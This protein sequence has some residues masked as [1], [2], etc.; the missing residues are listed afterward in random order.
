MLGQPETLRVHART[1]AAREPYARWS[2]SP[3][4]SRSRSRRP[5]IGSG[6]TPQVRLAGVWPGASLLAAAAGAIGSGRQLARGQQMVGQLGTG[7]IRHFSYVLAAT[8]DDNDLPGFELFSESGYGLLTMQ[9]NPV[10]V[11]GTIMYPP[12]RLS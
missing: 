7:T 9:F 10:M 12:V 1:R 2:F 5:A 11:N 3:V 8:F 4:F 6:L